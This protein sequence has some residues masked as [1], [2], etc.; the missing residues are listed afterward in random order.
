ML[1]PENLSA[2]LFI[3]VREANAWYRRDDGGLIVSKQMQKA[4][5]D[6][7]DAN[8][9]VAE[10]LGDSEQFLLSSGAS[11]KAKEFVDALKKAYSVETSRF[12]QR[13]LIDFIAASLPNVAYEYDRKKVRIFRGIGKPVG[14]EF[15]GEPV[16]PDDLP[17]P[18]DPDDTPF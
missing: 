5:A 1:L 15:V 11:V 7:L 9:F 10:F 14:S 3:L 2:L 4:T 13:D 17:P 6:Y 8:N 18:I 16:D 12:K